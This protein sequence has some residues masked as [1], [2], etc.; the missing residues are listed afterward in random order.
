MSVDYKSW[1]APTAHLDAFIT[2]TG[3]QKPAGTDWHG[4]DRQPGLAQ[5]LSATHARLSS[6]SHS[7]DAAQPRADALPAA[8][9]VTLY[10]S[11]EL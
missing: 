3:R 11:D 5:T 10:C 4:T 2:L 6:T 8:V 1:K 7:K 9:S